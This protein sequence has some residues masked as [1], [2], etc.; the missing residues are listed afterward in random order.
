MTCPTFGR[1]FLL[2]PWKWDTKAL[3]VPLHVYSFDGSA[4]TGTDISRENS[5]QCLY[6]L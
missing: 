5:V 2:L 1:D 3:L 6:N 4:I